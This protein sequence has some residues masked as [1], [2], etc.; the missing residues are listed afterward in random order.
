ML[1]PPEMVPVSGLNPYWPYVAGAR[2]VMFTG[3]QAQMLVITGAD[4][5]RQ[6]SG[7]E[8]EHA[9]GTFSHKFRNDVIVRAVIPRFA[10]VRFGEKFEINPLDL[11]IVEDWKTNELDVIELSKFHVMHQHYGF[12]FKFDDDVYHRLMTEKNARFTAGTIIANSPNVTP[13]G[14][15][16]YGVETNVAYISD[17]AGTE[18]G[19]KYSTSYAQKITSTGFESRVMSFGKR[20]YPVN[21]NGTLDIYKPLPDVGEFIGSNGLLAASRP[22][23][24]KYDAVCMTRNKLLKQV[25]GLDQTTWAIPGA[26][27]VDIKVLHNDR[28]KNP[29]LPEEMTRQF[30]KYYEADQRFY[31]E[32]I[33]VCLF[34]KGKYM[35]EDVNMTPRLWALLYE[36]IARAGESLVDQGLWPREQIDLLRIAK[37]FRGE[38]LDEWRVEVIFQYITSVSEGRKV[39]DIQG[40]K[41]VGASVVPDEDMPVDDFGNRAD[42]VIFSNSAVNRLNTGRQHE[43][44]VGAAG[45]DVIKRIRRN[46]GLPDVG[47]IPESQIRKTVLNQDL[48]A[49]AMKSFGYLMGFYQLVSPK[50]FTLMSRPNVIPEGRHLSHLIKVIQDG[51]HPYGLFIHL[52]SNS[53]VKMDHVIRTIKDGPYMPEMSPL[54]FRGLDGRMKRTKRNE[55]IGPNYYLCLEKTATDWSGISSSKLGPF[56]TPSKLTNADKFSSP[57]RETGTKTTGE[58]EWRNL[59]AAMGA[60]PLAHIADLNNNPVHHK[61]ACIS[62]YTSDT[63]TNLESVIDREKFKLGNH[64]PLQWVIHQLICSGKNISRA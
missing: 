36:A 39:T 41:G 10:S 13:D 57:G 50:L 35:A 52:P 9:R 8:R 53:G 45:R 3:N 62:I 30:R 40:S 17:P 7:L 42:V 54:T 6:Q 25:Y 44:V 37:N 56:G 2:Q 14:D 32:L 29:K 28:V 5:K 11:V 47:F 58:S 60:W 59:A 12:E 49:L 23:D 51:E 31:S 43:A 15:Y 55:L 19:V 61:E 22:Y 34:R 1:T 64:R 4:R 20:F 27:V 24:Q 48:N 38:K 16:T 26:R 63:P 46:F 33:K 21:I 18:D